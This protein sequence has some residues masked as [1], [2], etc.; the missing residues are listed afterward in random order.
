MDLIIKAFEL[1]TSVVCLIAAVVKAVPVAQG[2]RPREK[3]NHLR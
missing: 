1:T 2:K 3:K